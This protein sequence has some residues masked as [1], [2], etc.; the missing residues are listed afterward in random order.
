MP[1]PICIFGA[2]LTWPMLMMIGVL[3]LSSTPLGYYYGAFGDWLGFRSIPIWVW[4]IA[5]IISFLSITRRSYAHCRRF[6]MS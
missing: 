6:W 2:I 1:K 4:I 5:I 3:V